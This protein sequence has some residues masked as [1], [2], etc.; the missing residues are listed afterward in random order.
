MK[1]ILLGCSALLM[2]AACSND[3]IVNE[4]NDANLIKFAV[5][6][7]GNSRAADVYCNNNMFTDFN[8]FAW[9]GSNVYIP[10]DAVKQTNGTW[11]IDG[12]NR[13]WPETGTLDFYA[14]K[15]GDFDYA[16]KTFKEF[17]VAAT[18]ADQVDLVYALTTG[19]G[20][21]GAN[22]QAVTLN[23]RHAL[24]QIVFKA[25]NTNENLKV[26]VKG[27]GAVNLYGKG[28]YNFPTKTT[29]HNILHENA[30]EAEY[31]ETKA[32][33]GNWGESFLDQATN[34]YSTTFDAVTLDGI[35]EATNLTDVKTAAHTTKTEFAPAM[36][37]LPQTRAAAEIVDYSPAAE[38]TVDDAEKT[39]S[40]VWNDGFY[41]TITCDIYNLA[42]VGTETVE[43]QIYDTV[44]IA[45]PAS[46]AWEEGKKYIYTFIFGNGG[47][48]YTPDPDP[49]PVLV[50]ITFDVTIDEFVPVPGTDTPDL[51]VN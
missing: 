28:T 11:A 23:F 46:I 33:R 22:P 27:V 45:V 7:Q 39:P 5:T 9:Y 51:N 12:A 31:D 21:T 6:T 26:V 41:F 1:K 38:A 42:T 25:K 16:T 32:S 35:T 2:L 34:D 8:V 24:S 43:S 37:L 19:Q 14:Y 3:E 17:Q 48:G 30:T 15:N 47:P 10:G 18:V 4:Q 40:K 50:P 36:L 13:Y 29:S 20:K 44:T 49:E